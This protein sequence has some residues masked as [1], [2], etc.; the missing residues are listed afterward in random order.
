MNNMESRSTKS[1]SRFAS[2][3]VPTITATMCG[4]LTICGNDLPR[5]SV[6]SSTPHLYTLPVSVTS[7]LPKSSSVAEAAPGEE[8]HPAPN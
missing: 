5:E 3:N 8:C 4:N 2:L 7:T 1:V 6:E